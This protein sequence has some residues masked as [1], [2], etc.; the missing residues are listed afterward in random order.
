M[1]LLVLLCFSLFLLSTSRLVKSLTDSAGRRMS[2]E[3]C[4]MKSKKKK[5]KTVEELKKINIKTIKVYV[6][7]A[8]L[9]ACGVWFST[10][11]LFGL[12][13]LGWAFISGI[14]TIIMYMWLYSRHVGRRISI[15][16][17]ENGYRSFM[18]LFPI[19]SFFVGGGGVAFVFVALTEELPQL[20]ERIIMIGMV[21]LFLYLLIMIPFEF[22]RYFSLTSFDKNGIYNKCFTGKDIFISWDDCVD[23]GM[24]KNQFG[25]QRYFCIYFSKNM[26]PKKT[27][28]EI[29]KAGFGEDCIWVNSTK[30]LLA[31]V[32]YYVSEDK[33][34]RYSEE[35]V[36]GNESS[37]ELW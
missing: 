9:I 19:A 15:L 22:R 4:K 7:C 8:I 25:H 23:I 28:Q 26:L 5:I 32:L 3:R 30:E 13:V 36:I 29:E 24:A 16:Q 6:L 21:I 34:A 14:A 2:I 27:L 31:D 1:G 37:I 33:I 18:G 20:Y 35:K 17:Y 12:S 10:I 11:E